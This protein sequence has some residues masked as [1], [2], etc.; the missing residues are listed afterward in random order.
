MTPPRKM[1]PMKPPRWVLVRASVPLPNLH[2]GEIATVNITDPYIKQQLRS[3]WLV[4][5]PANQQPVMTT[6]PV[7]SQPVVG[8]PD[9]ATA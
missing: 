4:P 1:T 9:E 6:D 5:L 2:R 7:T 3:Q 8:T